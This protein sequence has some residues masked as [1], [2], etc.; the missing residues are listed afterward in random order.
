MVLF[1]AGVWIFLFATM[2]KLSRLALGPTHPPIQWV[3]G[4]LFP[5]KNGWRVKLTTDPHQVLRLRMSGAVALL[6]HIPSWHVLGQLYL[7][8]I[9]TASEAPNLEFSG[10]KRYRSWIMKLTTYPNQC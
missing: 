6:S 4:P 8:H 9:Q 3:P 2:S 7:Y 10:S 5:G 1:L